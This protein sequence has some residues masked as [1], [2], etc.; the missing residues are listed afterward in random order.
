MVNAYFVVEYFLVRAVCCDFFVAIRK[1]VDKL[2]SPLDRSRP[3]S[4]YFMGYILN[5][6]AS[7]SKL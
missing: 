4:G 2:L 5:A 3:N 6:P 1:L 7:T